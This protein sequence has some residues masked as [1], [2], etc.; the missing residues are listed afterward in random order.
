MFN[1]PNYFP[2]HLRQVQKEIE[3]PLLKFA[4][5]SLSNTFQKKKFLFF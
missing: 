3:R 2:P 5:V 4:G 1:D